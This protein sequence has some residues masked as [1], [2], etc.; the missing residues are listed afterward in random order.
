[1]YVYIC[2]HTHIYMYMN[3]Y[4]LLACILYM[5][6]GTTILVIIEAPTICKPTGYQYSWPV[7]PLF[8]Q[9]RPISAAH[10]LWTLRTK[11]ETKLGPHTISCYGPNIYIYIYTHV[12]IDTYIYVYIHITTCVYI[13][14]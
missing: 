3:T 1:M 8:V 7:Q 12:Y 11:W 9:L 14:T 6:R 10:L 4:I 13:Y 5:E 2:I